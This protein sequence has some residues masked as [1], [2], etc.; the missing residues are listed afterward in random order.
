MYL[1]VIIFHG[2]VPLN[3][4]FGRVKCWD[5][6]LDD[7]NF[8]RH[9][10][11]TPTFEELR[12]TAC[13]KFRVE[14]FPHY[15]LRA[16]Y[17]G[18]IFVLDSENFYVPNNALV[19]LMPI[20]HEMRFD[21]VTWSIA[22]NRENVQSRCKTNTIHGEVKRNNINSIHVKIAHPNHEYLEQVFNTQF[23][24]IENDETHRGTIANVHSNLG[25]GTLCSNVVCHR[26]TARRESGISWENDSDNLSG[27]THFEAPHSP[28]LMLEQGLDALV[29]EDNFEG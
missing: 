20:Y 25:F 13:S 11:H 18:I 15:T 26:S 6:D 17:N 19:L 14:F 5:T 28:F 2:I 1:P 27:S 24:S 4:G 8:I 29:F 16:K 23:K 10:D 7:L 9:F 12:D 22:Y 3:I 21:I